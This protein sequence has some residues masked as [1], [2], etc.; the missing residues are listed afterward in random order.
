MWD[1]AELG[2]NQ[3]WLQREVKGPAEVLWRQWA[4]EGMGGTAGG[5][6]LSRWELWV[7]HVTPS[8]H[9]LCLSGGSVQRQTDT[10][11]HQNCSLQWDEDFF[12]LFPFRFWSAKLQGCS[13]VLLL[14]CAWG[15][16]SPRLFWR[17]V[18]V[19][20][21]P[22]VWSVLQHTDFVLVVTSCVWWGGRLGGVWERATH[23]EFKLLVFPPP[24][25]RGHRK[26]RV[27]LDPWKGLKNKFTWDNA[28]KSCFKWTQIVLQPFLSSPCLLAL[29]TLPSHPS[30]P[31]LSLFLVVSLLHWAKHSPFLH[32]WTSLAVLSPP[33]SHCSFSFAVILC[34]PPCNYFLEV[35]FHLSVRCDQST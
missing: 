1:T 35:Y 6:G 26:E 25:L 8:E 29:S 5:A 18:Q 31:L 12:W 14:A 9:R 22:T 17:P 27:M 11:A 19:W 15:R 3:G 23:T 2:K 20:T 13:S 16:N 21:S 10:Q 7:P 4:G 24:F 30:Q 32:V 34:F 33:S 28:Q